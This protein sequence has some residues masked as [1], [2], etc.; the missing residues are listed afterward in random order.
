MCN[1]SGIKQAYGSLLNIFSLAFSHVFF[2]E[3]MCVI[4]HNSSPSALEKNLKIKRKNFAWWDQS[5]SVSL[6]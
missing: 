3:Y 1:K 6:L 5:K 2:I 4:S